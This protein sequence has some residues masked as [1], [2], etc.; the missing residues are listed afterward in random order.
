MK[1][2]GSVALLFSLGTLCFADPVNLDNTD[3]NSKEN[4]KGFIQVS[5]EYKE[6]IKINFENFNEEIKIKE[7]WPDYMEWMCDLKRKVYEFKIAVNSFSN[8][9]SN[10]HT[11]FFYLD[12]IFNEKKI[13]VYIY[14]HKF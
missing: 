11:Q 13:V 9:I 7:E 5:K 14:K 2:P 6:P 8:G 3:L 10:E 12:P 1:L 4:I